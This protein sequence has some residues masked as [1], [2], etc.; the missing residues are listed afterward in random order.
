MVWRKNEE[1]AWEL[2][3]NKKGSAGWYGPEH[4]EVQTKSL[5]QE[6]HQPDALQLGDRIIGSPN[7]WASLL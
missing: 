6:L 7:D 2:H 5:Y 1:L 4:I 3:N